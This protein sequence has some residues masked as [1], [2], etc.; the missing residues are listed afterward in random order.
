MDKNLE[1]SDID[2]D[3]WTALLEHLEEIDRKSRE[4]YG[5]GCEF[6]GFL[7]PCTSR[8]CAKT[9]IVWAPNYGEIDKNFGKIPPL[10]ELVRSFSME[11]LLFEGHENGGK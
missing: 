2:A 3:I 4:K 10:R 7:E 1:F 5:F 6:Y 9:H 8:G 11:K